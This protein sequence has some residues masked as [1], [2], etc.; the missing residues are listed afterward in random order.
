MG[1][2]DDGWDLSDLEKEIDSAIDSIL[3]DKKSQANPVTQPKEIHSFAQEMGATDSYR[4]PPAASPPQGGRFISR[5]LQEKLEAVEAQLLT[6]EWDISSKHINSA[7]NLLQDLR[8][9]PRVEDELEKAII[10]IQKIL[11][12]FILDESKLTP[13]AVKFLQRSW[14]A[15]KG[16]T[17]E[18]FSFEI[19]KKALVNELKA[20]FQR[21]RI[22]E[23]EPKEERIT[24]RRPLEKER[25]SLEEE[26]V[27]REPLVE[28]R[29]SFAEIQKL[30]DRIQRLARVVNEERKRWEDIH[31][32]ITNFT[33]ELQKKLRFKE[34]LRSRPEEGEIVELDERLEVGSYQ[35]PDLVLHQPARTYAMSVSLFE[36]SGV[37]FALPEK[38]IVKSFPIKKWVSD[39]FIERG[40]VKLKNREIP[41]FNL[42]QVFKLRPSMEE[43]PL[44][45]LFRGREDRPI[46]VIIDRAISREEI[47]YHP[48]DDKPFIVGK[49]ISRSGEVWILD[50]EQLSL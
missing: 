9:S 11:Y 49:G 3:V 28:A 7:I 43:N 29:I 1:E 41:L 2:N 50:A 40:N 10:L 18:R 24:T 12:Q 42:F 5:E 16:M 32:E 20:E 26:V 4:P 8:D 27:T 44:V 34:E 15:V 21:L 6:L 23:G 25:I 47:E 22:E 46:A 19:D 37:I 36:V 45:L 13:S 38:Q 48:V 14:K 31:Q 35:S 30:M 33:V 17:D 39:F